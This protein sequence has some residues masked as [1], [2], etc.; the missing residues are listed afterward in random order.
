MIRAGKLD[1]KLTFQR[2]TTTLSEAGTPQEAWTNLA[3]MRAEKI[4]GV[5]EEETRRFGASSETAFTFRMRW[6]EGLTLADRALYEGETYT[7]SSIRE[8]GRR[9]GLEI[10]LA[11]IANHA[12]T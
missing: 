6:L 3:A 2:A 1:R 4:E 9:R 12:G 7:I 5:T 8:L 11:R 10:Q